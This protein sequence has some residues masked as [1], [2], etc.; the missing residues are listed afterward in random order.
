METTDDIG[1]TPLHEAVT[2]IGS[3]CDW[4]PT[5]S[6]HITNSQDFMRVVKILISKGVG[7]SPTDDDGNTPLHIAAFYGYPKMVQ[8]LL[9]NGADLVSVNNR[10]YTAGQSAMA[11]GRPEIAALI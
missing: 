2:S 7:V 5:V 10:G 9:D 8:V 4:G 6:A 11:M 1:C 3:D